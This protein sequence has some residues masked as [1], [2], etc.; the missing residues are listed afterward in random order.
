MNALYTVATLLRFDSAMMDHA[1]YCFHITLLLPTSTDSH[2][3]ACVLTVTLLN[4]PCIP[5]KRPTPDCCLCYVYT[6]RFRHLVLHFINDR[7]FCTR[8]VG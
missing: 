6:Y 7:C 4:A 1:I 3:P 5:R 8:A 2:C